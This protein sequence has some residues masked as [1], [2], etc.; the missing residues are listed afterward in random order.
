MCLHFELIKQ[1]DNT[2]IEAQQSLF[3]IECSEHTLLHHLLT[4]LRVQEL[5]L[6]AISIGETAGKDFERERGHIPHCQKPVGEK[7]QMLDAAKLYRSI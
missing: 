7:V 4:L 5:F 2:Q 3:S 6:T 1:I